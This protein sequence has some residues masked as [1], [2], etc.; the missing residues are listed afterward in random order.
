[1]GVWITQGLGLKIRAARRKIFS[2][3]T[4]TPRSPTAAEGS[5]KIAAPRLG[6]ARNDEFVVKV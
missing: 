5:H 2:C 6:G 1:M 4:L 3:Q